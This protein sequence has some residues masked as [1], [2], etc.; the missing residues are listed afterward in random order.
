MSVN[1]DWILRFNPDQKF[2]RQ[3]YRAYALAIGQASIAW[4]Y[5]QEELGAAFALLVVK[6]GYD[7]AT[8]WYANNFDRPRRELLKA[9]LSKAYEVDPTEEMRQRRHHVHTEIL[10]VISEADKLE[11]LR[12]TILH[13]PIS[14]FDDP[15]IGFFPA[16]G[17]SADKSKG[18]PRAKKLQEADDGLRQ[19]RWFRD[20]AT[21]LGNYVHVL[22]W[23]LLTKAE[24]FPD[25]PKL[26]N[27]GRKKDPRRRN[28]R[29]RAK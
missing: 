4:N 23:S 7:G 1:T 22:Y 3:E 11:E 15:N 20:A 29:Q 19:I 26:P 17:V 14:N 28:R 18:N 25:R 6:R 16:I 27:R 10:W 9:A 5:L 21:I 8:V 13:S 2:S 12:N 24:T